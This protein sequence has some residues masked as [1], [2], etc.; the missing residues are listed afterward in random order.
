ML[1]N[2]KHIFVNILG[3]CLA[4]ESNLICLSRN[5]TNYLTK[6]F[7]VILDNKML[8][9]L[10]PLERM[11]NFLTKNSFEHLNDVSNWVYRF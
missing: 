10:E 8:K 1:R 5:A 2:L 7:H 9:N 11:K 4:C 6:P 3:A